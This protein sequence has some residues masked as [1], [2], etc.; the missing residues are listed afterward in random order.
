MDEKK[1]ITL[2]DLMQEMR[3]GFKAA[4]EYS[5]QGFE[6]MNTKIDTVESGIYEKIDSVKSELNKKI[7]GVKRELTEEIGGV[8]SSLNEKIEPLRADRFTPDEKASILDTVKLVN[9]HLADNVTGKDNITLTRKE[10]DV[11]AEKVGL[12]NK[13]VGSGLKTQTA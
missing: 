8:K 4:R 5:Q 11:V 7:D 3:A 9:N 12:P 13:F 6:M 1:E 10:Y 2:E